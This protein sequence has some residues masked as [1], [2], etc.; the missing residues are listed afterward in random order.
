[1]IRKHTVIIAFFIIFVV[2][3]VHHNIYDVSAS[4][5]E[6]TAKNTSA[7]IFQKSTLKQN[8]RRRILY[9]ISFLIR[10]CNS[11][12]FCKRVFFLTNIVL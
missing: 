3:L 8:S 7:T 2:A 11:V 9:V 6:M 4:E 1:M 5:I 10:I 12:P